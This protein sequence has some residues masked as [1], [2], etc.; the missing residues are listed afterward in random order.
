[1]KTG[2]RNVIRFA[3]EC[4][5]EEAKANAEMVAALGTVGSDADRAVAKRIE[6]LNWTADQLRE[7]I[8]PK[9]RKR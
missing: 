6:K 2:H 1:M 5:E 7:M 8:K 4:L 9:R 3:A